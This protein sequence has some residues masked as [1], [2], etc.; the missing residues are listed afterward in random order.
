MSLRQALQGTAFEPSQPS[1]FTVEG[2]VYYLPE[3]A[4]RGLLADIAALGAPG[5]RVQFDFLHLDC[6]LG[7]DW[8]PAYRVTAQVGF[9]GYLSELVPPRTWTN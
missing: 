1:L 7:E 9:E 8:V 3:G 4:V 2:L 5:S 6:L